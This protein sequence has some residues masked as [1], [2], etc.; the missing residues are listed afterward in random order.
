MTNTETTYHSVEIGRVDLEKLDK[1]KLY[2]CVSNNTIETYCAL[3]YFKKADITHI[4]LSETEYRQMFPECPKCK[5]DWE[6]HMDSFGCWNCG[7]EKS[8]PLPVK[9]AMEILE[10]KFGYF[11][12]KKLLGTPFSYA[13][14]QVI[15]A[16]EIYANQFKNK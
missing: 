8:S 4:L 5:M 15:E 2:F 11:D 16:M 12:G 3:I 6:A 7:Y 9:T 1:T 14:H 13:E 10:E